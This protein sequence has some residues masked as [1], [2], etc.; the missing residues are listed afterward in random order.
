[1]AKSELAKALSDLNYIGLSV[2]FAAALIVSVLLLRVNQL[3]RNMPER[4]VRNLVMCDATYIL[5]GGFICVAGRVCS[6]WPVF[7]FFVLSSA[8]WTA[9]IGVDWMLTSHGHETITYERTFSVIVY[10]VALVAILPMAIWSDGYTFS[11]DNGFCVPNDSVATLMFPIAKVVV[12][13]I[14]MITNIVVFVRTRMLLNQ[15]EHELRE[16]VRRAVK[17]RGRYLLIYI[18][19]WTPFLLTSGYELAGRPAPDAVLFLYFILF[20]WQAFA[21]AICFSTMPPFHLLQRMALICSRGIFRNVDADLWAESMTMTGDVAMSGSYSGLAPDGRSGAS[22]NSHSVQLLS[23]NERMANEQH[24]A[25]PQPMLDALAHD[26]PLVLLRRLSLQEFEIAWYRLTLKRI[27]GSG[28]EGTVHEALLAPASKE[29]AGAGAGA[30]AG[31]AAGARRWL[32]SSKTVAVKFLDGGM[33]YSQLKDFVREASCLRT[34]RHG[35][36]LEFYGVT[37]DQL[38]RRVAIVSE[39]C[40]GGTLSDALYRNKRTRGIVS[41]QRQRWAMEV[42]AGLSQ[43]AEQGMLHRDLKPDNILLDAMQR[44]KI[45]DFGLAR[46]DKTS[47]GRGKTVQVGTPAYMAPELYTES[48]KDYGSEVDVYSFGL[49]LWT[50]VTRQLP[51]NDVPGDLIVLMR[52]ICV[53]GLRPVIPQRV[54]PNLGAIIRQCWAADPRDR[55]QLDEHLEDR[56]SEEDLFV[57]LQSPVAEEQAEHGQQQQRRR[58]QQQQQQRR[59]QTGR[60]LGPGA[61]LDHHSADHPGLPASQRSTGSITLSSASEGNESADSELHKFNTADHPGLP[62]S[63]G[64]SATLPRASEGNESAGSARHSIADH[65]GLHAS[66]AASTDPAPGVPPGAGA[67]GAAGAGEEELFVTAISKTRAHANADPHSFSPDELEQWLRSLYIPARVASSFKENG[68]CGKDVDDWI[69]TGNT[70]VVGE[71]EVSPGQLAK[72]KRNWQEA[73]AAFEAETRQE[74]LGGG[75]AEAGGASEAATGSGEERFAHVDVERKVCIT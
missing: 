24:N 64:T 35:N 44:C 23:T 57:P 21:N 65:P 16:H 10:S 31:V 8:S 7:G 41:N 58:R 75:L 2:S 36:V 19:C 15:R 70:G 13:G 29:G 1:M 17:Y 50:L 47:K 12:A 62:T 18:V 5:V 33:D 51:Y 6:L 48:S 68:V 30:G 11:L 43:I 4:L 39:F 66:P 60:Q 34:V 61:R 55:P 32:R 3:V 45:A 67:A 49:L 28:A 53:E 26:N 14:A 63:A 74:A 71:C 25:F 73:L 9:I 42:C 27:V 46:L 20:T 69:A 52:K 38:S 40:P 37:F 59:Q 22:I 56:L 72:L 54:R